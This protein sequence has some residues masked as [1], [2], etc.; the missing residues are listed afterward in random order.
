[1]GVVLFP[2]DKRK[3]GCTDLTGL[4]AAVVLPKRPKS[5][6]VAVAFHGYKTWSLALGKEYKLRAVENR[7]LE[8]TFG[9]RRLMLCIRQRTLLESRV[10]GLELIRFRQRSMVE[11]C[12]N[13]SVLLA[14]SF[15][16]NKLAINY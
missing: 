10:C 8:R 14:G 6:N 4:A 7:L 2:A 13:G 11:C 12:E 5:A 16:G 15:L 3:N 1:M 9:Y